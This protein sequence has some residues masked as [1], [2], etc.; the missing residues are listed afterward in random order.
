MTYIELILKGIISGILTAFLLVY[1]LRP[2]VPYPDIILEP[3]EHNWLFII[4][5]V[6][7]YYL[8]LWDLKIGVLMLLSIVALLFDLFVF[9][10]NGIEKKYTIVNNSPISSNPIE[11]IKNMYISEPST[12][13]DNNLSTD[14]YINNNIYELKTLKDNTNKIDLIPGEPASFI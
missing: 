7:N 2:S 13:K 10:Y 14:T 12:S 4:L 1:G 11:F 3:F 9:T 6:I 8:L 5:F